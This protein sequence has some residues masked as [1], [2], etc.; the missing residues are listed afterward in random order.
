MSNSP[1]LTQVINT[2]DLKEKLIS[3]PFT[4]QQWYNIDLNRIASKKDKSWMLGK[5][6][7][8]PH[9]G[10]TWDDED[11][12]TVKWYPQGITGLRSSPEL[13]AQH[14][15]IVVSWYGKDDYEYKGVRLSFVDVTDMDKISYRHVLLV[16]PSDDNKI[17][18]PIP[19]HAGGLAT[20]DNI[21]YVADTNNGIRAFDTRYIFPAN[22]DL[23]L[24]NQCGIINGK[25]Y[26]FDYRY[27]LPQSA[28]YKMIMGNQKFSF[29]SMDW[30][31]INNPKLI[32]GNYHSSDPKYY[33]PPPK[34]V[35]WGL[36]ETTI[37][38]FTSS[39][40][41]N[42][43]RVQGAVSLNSFLWLSQSGGDNAKLQVMRIG[44][45]VFKEFNWPSGCEDLHYSP[46]SKNLWCLTEHPGNR[47]VFA[48]KLDDYSL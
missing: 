6:V 39:F 11:S 13:D 27:I 18:K 19:I 42:V 30:S 47:F 48:V 33:N 35:W 3:H 32:T 36:N 7:G 2:S 1:V 43:E 14:K 25:V 15:Y 45:R 8:C 16:Q 41:T 37:G 24:K 28:H 23:P 29:T 38:N 20:R 44:D 21:I 17:F 22:A 34:I 10:F 46:Y 12:G 40:Q 31:D 26:A 5:K 9:V 4:P